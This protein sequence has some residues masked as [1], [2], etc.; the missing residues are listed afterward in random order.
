MNSNNSM[1]SGMASGGSGGMASGGSGGM[2]GGMAN[3]GQNQER[4]MQNMQNAQFKKQDFDNLRFAISN[5]FEEVIAK[6]EN[7]IDSVRVDVA[8][9]EI[10]TNYYNKYYGAN[11][12]TVG[13]VIVPF[14]FFSSFFAGFN[15]VASFSFLILFAFFAMYHQVVFFEANTRHIKVDKKFHDLIFN[16][17]FPKTLNL[18]KLII[19]ILIL[20]AISVLVY[21]NPINLKFLDNFYQIGFFNFLHEKMSFNFDYFLYATINLINVMFLIILRL[22]ERWGL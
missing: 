7:N 1:S 5:I 10:I 19:A 13:L 8:K 6:N 9:S 3:G 21:L 16:K 14:A 18:K 17:L 20:Y 11:V 2:A 12:F 4:I 22:I 15:I